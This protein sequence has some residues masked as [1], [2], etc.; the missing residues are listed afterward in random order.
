MVVL[1]SGLCGGRSMCEND[2][3]APWNTLSLWLMNPGSVILEYAHA[4]GE[5]R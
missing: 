1:R 3:L 5:S 2:V 4:I